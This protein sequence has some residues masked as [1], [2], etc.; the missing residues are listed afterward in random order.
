MHTL[1]WTVA[2]ACS[3]LALIQ[4]FAIVGAENR[5][6]RADHLLSAIGY[7]GIAVWAWIVLL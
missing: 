6:K 7:G 5:S 3:I 2:I 4:L 1:V